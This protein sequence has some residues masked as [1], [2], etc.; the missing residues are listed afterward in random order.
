MCMVNLWATH[1]NTTAK[2][3]RDEKIG[4]NIS[5]FVEED[6]F[7]SGVNVCVCLCVA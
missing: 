4:Q 2:R 6:E 1:W 3:P 7:F 5:F